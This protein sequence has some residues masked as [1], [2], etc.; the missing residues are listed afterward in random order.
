MRRCSN[1]VLLFQALKVPWFQ[2]LTSRHVWAIILVHGASVYGFFT[3]T[4]QLPTY[5]KNILNVNIKEV[6][7]VRKDFYSFET[8]TSSV[9]NYVNI[10]HNEYSK[11]KLLVN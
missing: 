6:C 8:Q 3:I 7:T 11:P 2:M 9:R 5:M 4:N 1:S 10:Q